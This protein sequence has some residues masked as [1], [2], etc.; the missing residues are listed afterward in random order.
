MHIWNEI[1]PQPFQASAP[2]YLIIM[3]WMQLRLKALFLA[4]IRTALMN[5]SGM[6]FIFLIGACD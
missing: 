6:L 3:T 4:V 2:W 1:R 5:R